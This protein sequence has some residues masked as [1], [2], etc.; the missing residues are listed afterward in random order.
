M[1]IDSKY[2]LISTVDYGRLGARRRGR[3]IKSWVS[4]FLLFQCDDCR[5]SPA[6]SNKATGLENKGDSGRF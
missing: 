2:P 3:I 4:L 6:S 1:Q 5:R